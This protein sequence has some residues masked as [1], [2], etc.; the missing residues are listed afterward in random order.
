MA[1]GE[2]LGEALRVLRACGHDLDADQVLDVLWLAR[3]LP[4]GKVA[5][6]TRDLHAPR[7][8]PPE[9][10]ATA[11]DTE[12]PPAPTPRP[13]GDDL[14]DLTAPSLYASARSAP[15]RIPPP[16]RRPEPRPRSAMPVRVPESKALGNELELGRA[17][18]PLRRRHASRHRREIDE[19]RT[20]AELAETGLPDVVQRPV[21]ERWLHLVLLVDDGLS[22]LLWHRLGAELRVLLERLGAFATT[23]VLGLDTRSARG[24]RL[25]A[26]PFEQ[27]STSLPTTTVNDPTGRTLVLVV[28][29]GMGT[30]WRHPALYELLRTW[31]DRGPVALLHTLPPDMWEASGIRAERWQATTRHIGGANTSW[32]IADPVLPGL[33]RF[34]GVPVPV[35]EPTAR[36]LGD[37]ARLL[38]SP[39]TTMELPLLSRPSPYAAVTA[40]GDLHSA[41]HFR[42]AATPEAYRL[43]AHLAAVSPLSVP[44]MRLVQTAV[45]WPARTSHLAEVFLGGL[46]R[47]HPAPVPGPL[48]AKH[49]VFDFSEDAKSVLLDAVPQ[50]ELLSTSRSIGRRLE[51][52]AGNSPDFPAWL[53]HP[54]GSAELPVSHRPFTSVE[55]RLL[56]RFGVPVGRRTG[57]PTP[58][59]P[60]PPADDD[61]SPLT[62]TD[63]RRLGPYELRGRRRGRRTV[64]YRAVDEHGRWAVLR[65]PRPDLPAA[66]ARLLEVEAKVLARLHGRYAPSLLGTGLDDSPPW[67][68]MAPVADADAPAR[69]PPRLADLVERSV[70][71]GTAPFDVLA[72]L[73][74]AWHLASALSVCHTNDIV[75]ADLGADSV[76]V[77]RRSV[78]LA[79]L[80]DCA[81]DGRYAG[82]GP[83]PTKADSVR[84]LGEL[85]Q[86]ISSK[87][88]V[89]LPG[90]PE[91][92]HLWQGDTWGQLRRL[93][94]R[95]LDDDPDERPAAGEVADVLARYI[96]LKRATRDAPGPDPDPSG[97]PPRQPLRLLLN[98]WKP[99]EAPLRLPRSRAARQE[100]EERLDRLRVPLRYGVRLALLGVHSGCGRRTTTVVLGSLLA[101]VRGEPVL[102]LDGA[103]TM[104]SLHRFLENREPGT[105]RDLALLPGDASYEQIRSR[106]TRLGS[107]L[108]LAAHRKGRAGPNPA[109]AQEYSRVLQQTDPYY[110]FVLTDWGGRWPTRSAEVVLDLTDRLLLCCGPSPWDVQIAENILDELRATRHAGLVDDALIVISNRDGRRPDLSSDLAERQR[111]SPSQVV[112]IPYDTYL[113]NNRFQSLDKLRPATTHAYLELAERVVPTSTH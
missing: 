48:P 111:I 45:P 58:P 88:G 75:P 96:D 44:V 71:D 8:A 5:P 50:A 70:A 20:A 68:A 92:M 77:L 80:S 98:S 63:P 3:R 34:E 100:T 12:T 2:R 85:L 99:T 55:R 33:A 19:E 89:H 35:L 10:S 62:D 59:D 66:N 27:H 39:G 104:G 57:G 49:R 76:I 46:V 18:R 102:A 38:A 108:E 101:A 42:D 69:Q 73:L 110:A 21:Q 47:P 103:P 95:C 56:E 91:G 81:I 65:T 28:S 16:E 67:L 106:T 36:A 83:V 72:G 26:R 93:V 74:V 31:A 53:A 113:R 30:A 43:A 7:P 54:D 23:R 82:T 4:A 15:A 9:A 79:D 61:W 41:Q 32:Q 13:E 52:L 11:S 40:A 17:L 84:A 22:M 112:R 87:A 25:H 14:P 51:Q 64:A 86:L 97:P 60:Q 109:H 94:L 105:P 107:G 6:L 37:W 1:G 24:P 78:V 29:D 90:L